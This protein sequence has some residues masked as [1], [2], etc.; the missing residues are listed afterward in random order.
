M[1]N[2]FLVCGSSQLSLE[3]RELTFVLQWP[4]VVFI[5]VFPVYVLRFIFLYSSSELPML[6]LFKGIVSDLGRNLVCWLL[7]L[8]F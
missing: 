2:T 6:K 4:V 3:V 8:V 1:Q 7:Q 5:L